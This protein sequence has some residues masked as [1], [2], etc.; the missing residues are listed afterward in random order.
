MIDPQAPRLPF[1]P[2]RANALLDEAG[3]TERRGG[4]R[5]DAE[6]RRLSFE[7]MTT[8]G[9]RSRELVQQVIQANWRAVGVDTAIRNEPARV[10]F[11]QTMSRRAFSALA[12]FAWVSSPENVPRTILHSDHIPT[13]A[14][15]WAGQNYTGLRNAEMDRLIEAIDVE[16]DRERRRALWHRFQALYAEDLPSLPLFWRADAHILPRWLDGVV[17]T[18]HQHGTSLWVEHWRRSGS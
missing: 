10:F 7:F 18:G 17:P 11:G 5:Q 1:D 9:N 3:F 13:A 6:G 4:V 2:D 14:N 12:L 15:N 16:L 8:A